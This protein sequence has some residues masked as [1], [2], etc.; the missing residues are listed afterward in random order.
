[1]LLLCSFSPHPKQIRLIV[2]DSGKFKI[3]CESFS[4]KFKVFPV[5]IFRTKAWN[6]NDPGE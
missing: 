2:T 3:D 6:S 1:M 4:A 5:V